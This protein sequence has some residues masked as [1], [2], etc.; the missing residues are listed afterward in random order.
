M[1]R[2]DSDTHLRFGKY[3]GIMV[4]DV[5]RDYLKWALKK[6]LLTIKQTRYAMIELGLPKRRYLGT[7][8]ELGSDN[9]TKIIEAYTSRDAMSLLIRE[10][11]HRGGSYNIKKI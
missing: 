2:P 1:K 8:T 11:P 4:K 10:C 9:Y 7:V 6:D 5:P 3:K